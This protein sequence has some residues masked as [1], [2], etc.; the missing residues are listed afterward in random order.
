MADTSVDNG[1]STPEAHS[2]E[3]TTFPVFLIHSKWSLNKLD[4]FLSNYGDV[5]FLRIV[6]DKDGNETDR[7]IAVLPESVY[8]ALCKDGFDKRQYG[9]GFVI[10]RYSLRENNFPGEERTSTLFVPVPKDLSADDDTVV[11]AI[12]DKL[13][14]LSEWEIIP[15]NSWSVNAPLKS[16]EKGGIRG[17]CFVSFKRDVPLSCRAMVRV[18]LSDTYWPASDEGLTDER[19]VFHCFWARAH[20]EHHSEKSFSKKEEESDEVKEAKKVESIQKLAKKAKPAKTSTVP[21]KKAV[22][23]SESKKAA[24][25]AIPKGSQPSLK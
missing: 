22:K 21:T 12:D 25:V 1:V 7:N 11:S 5:G 9:K 15:E 6:F 14:H 8:T 24:T 4:T 19:S 2:I 16:R 13:K 3:E 23:G 10:S 17:G 18:L 20:K